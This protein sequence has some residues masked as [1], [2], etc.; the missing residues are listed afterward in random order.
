MRNAAPD[1]P[2]RERS[3]LNTML[4]VIAALLAIIAFDLVVGA[5]APSE[6]SAADT[7]PA[8]TGRFNPAVQRHE[9]LIELRRLNGQMNEV[10]AALGGAIEVDVVRMPAGGAGD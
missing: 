3:Y 8:G 4:T 6:A 1:N 5:P 10:N 9:M 7:D 2:N